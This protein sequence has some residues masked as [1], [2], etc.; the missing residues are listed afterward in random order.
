M[1]SLKITFSGIISAIL[2]FSLP[3]TFY[4]QIKLE[5]EGYFKAPGFRFLIY[6]NTY[7]GGRLGGLEMIMQGKRVL[8][9]GNV[10]CKLNDGKTYG[11]YTDSNDKRGERAVDVDAGKVSYPVVLTP[12][13]MKYTTN[14]ISD[15]SSITVRIDLDKPV[16]WNVISDISFRIEIYPE[17]YKDNTFNG[18]GISS[19]FYDQHFGRKVLIPKAKEI[20]IAPEDP[21]KKIVFE[22]E[23][24]T[25]SL[26][27]ERRDFNIS[28]YMLFASLEKGSTKRSFSLKIKPTI[29]S[30]W[31]KEPV[32]EVSQVG[33]H[34]DQQKTAI[35]EVQP[36][37]KNIKDL[38]IL[39][40]N[41]NYNI[42]TVATLPFKKWGDLYQNTYYTCDFTLIKDPGLYFLKYGDQRFGP[43]VIS[44]TVFRSA[45]H[46]TADIYF[47]T[48]MCHV[49]VK[50]FLRIWHGACHLDDAL[51]AKP[52]H[53]GKDGYSQGPETQTKFKPL[54][55]IPGINWGGWH[56]AADFDLPSGSIA[57]T[58]LWM[59]LAQEKFKT[60]RDVTT[61]LRDEH[62]VNL[63]E[64]D[65]KNDLLQQVA[66]GME[67][68]L[69]VVKQTGHVPSGVITHIGPDYG[70]NGDPAS[71][72][73]GLVYDP[74]LGKTE[75]KNCR[76]GKFD[77][78]WLYTDRNTG[79]QYQF[80]QV[81]ALSSRIF[82]GFDEELSKRCLE[83]AEEI[84][85]YEQSH[86]PVYFRSGYNPK[87]DKYH[88]LEMAAATELFLTTGDEKYREKLL[89]YI[90]VIKEMPVGNF[91][92]SGFELVRVKDKVNDWEFSDVLYAKAKKVKENLDKELKATPFDAPVHLGWGGTWVM[93]KNAARY[94]YFVEAYPELFDPEIV[95][96]TVNYVLG[97]HPA[98]N[99]SYV[100]GVGAKSAE[101]V[102]GFN[103]ADKSYQPGGVISGVTLVKP[104][105]VEYR[106]R[107]WDYYSTEH[108]I[109]GSSAYIFD[110]LAADY[111]LNRNK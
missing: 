81:A 69:A 77:D 31:T 5:Q 109:S 30:H 65:G 6:H 9:G 105:F 42:D 35:L 106:G 92:I 79:G 7:I 74:E 33:Y 61:V 93:L 94:F 95:Y 62:L 73:D 76:S 3:S 1:N 101:V 80:V 75:Q 51:Q 64:P 11:Y 102:Y 63:F 36:E 20:V 41:D 12:L 98:S 111:L 4:S 99:H 110:A 103:R 49:K 23:N 71:I 70:A 84:W 13:D 100:S 53:K 50:D 25:L 14:V 32:L 43:V 21:Q 108:V 96:T 68:F 26:R 57:Q 67:W 97:A 107:A 48:Q 54:E 66:F 47:P 46:E 56:D 29:D 28:G 88:S 44:D 85:D 8:D 86:E 82:K 59:A 27:D 89:S 90:P 17:E 22:G 87:E 60:T 18:G 72:T 38:R 91:N 2:L 34:P 78:R 104:D 45:W 15:G 40:L 37:T 24:V 19:Y 52:N 39:Y 55:H 16:D 58:A 83:S 10:V